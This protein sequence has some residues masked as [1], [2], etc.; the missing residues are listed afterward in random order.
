MTIIF[1]VDRS[2]SAQ[3]TTQVVTQVAA[4]VRTQAP[5]RNPIEDALRAELGVSR[6]SRSAAFHWADVVALNIEKL[7]A[8]LTALMKYKP[9]ENAPTIKVVKSM[10]DAWRAIPP[11]LVHTPAATPSAASAVTQAP[12]E[13]LESRLRA[14]TGCKRPSAQTATHYREFVAEQ[15]QKLQAFILYMNDESSAHLD[16]ALIV[17]AHEW[18]AEW[19]AI[20]ADKLVEGRNAVRTSASPGDSGGPMNAAPN[21][22]RFPLV[23]FMSERNIA[24]LSRDWPLAN[25][26]DADILRD[27][28]KEAFNM[29]A[30]IDAA[31]RELFESSTFAVYTPEARAFADNKLA[32][33]YAQWEKYMAFLDKRAAFRT[34]EDEKRS[35][36]DF[37]LDGRGNSGGS[38]ASRARKANISSRDAAIRA[39]LKGG[40]GKGKK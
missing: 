35:R 16:G 13:S 15:A 12:R 5:R 28:A 33:A 11:E 3:V 2:P 20:P 31:G 34:K 38:A 37:N 17:L 9:F 4:E 23:T 36:L 32:S 8:E 18:Y 6:P 25:E 29:C 7:E 24:F 10:L 27:A 22:S 39:S 30:R 19:K 1:D 21:Y 26:L 40:A 14:L